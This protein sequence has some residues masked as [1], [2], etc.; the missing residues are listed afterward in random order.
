MSRYIFLNLNLTELP[1]NILTTQQLMKCTQGSLLRSCDVCFYA[2]R[3]WPET[4]FHTNGLLFGWLYT[5]SLPFFC[6]CICVSSKPPSPLPSILCN[7]VEFFRRLLNEDCIPKITKLR[8]LPFLVLCVGNKKN[9]VIFSLK[10][11]FGCSDNYD[12][13]DDY[14]EDNNDNK[15]S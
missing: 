1:K 8:R 7:N 15:D 6:L 3:Y 4:D 10:C 9:I 12:D 5:L 2:F 11:P 13:Y 14:D